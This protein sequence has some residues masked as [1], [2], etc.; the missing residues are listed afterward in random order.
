MSL[1]MRIAT[2]FLKKHL[3]NTKSLILAWLLSKRR[4]KFQNIL[5]TAEKA[6]VFNLFTW[7]GTFVPCYT[8]TKKRRVTAI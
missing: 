5:K 7:R 6:R 8:C 2:R 4:E 1:K 3:G